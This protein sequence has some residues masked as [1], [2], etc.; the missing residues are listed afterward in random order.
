MSP[1]A[2]KYTYKHTYTRVTIHY[3]ALIHLATRW[4]VF[5]T[6]TQP[7]KSTKPGI[8]HKRRASYEE[9][10]CGYATAKNETF[11]KVTCMPTCVAC[12]A[13]WLTRPNAVI[14]A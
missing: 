13:V 5:D 6:E 3:D 4:I 1:R 14:E 11:E 10:L 9:T 12:L 2:I 7:G 8:L